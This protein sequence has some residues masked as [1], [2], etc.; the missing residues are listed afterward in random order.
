MT[1]KLIYGIQQIG[2]GVANADE[3][4]KWYATKLGADALIFDDS[5]EATYMA[6]Y[7]GGKS[8]KKRALLALNMQ[9]GGGFEIWQ[10]SNRTPAAPKNTF[11]IGDLG[12]QFPFIKTKDIYKTF[13]RL[14]ESK[15]NIISAICEEPDNSKSFYLKDPFNNILKIKEYSSWYQHNKLDVGGIF[16]AAIGVSNIETSLKL[17]SDILGYDTVVYDKSGVFKD[18][19]SLENGNTKVRR[20]LLSHS[21]ERTGGFS[22]LFGA[23]QIELIQCLEN[24]PDKIFVDRFWGDLGYIH[25]CFDI[26]NMDVLK[27]ECANKGVPF[28]VISTPSFDM[29]EAN[30]H[31]GYIEDFDGTLIEF[32][33]THKVPLIK[34]LGININLKNRDVKKPLP[35]WM[36]K[37]MNLKKVKKFKSKI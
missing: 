37:A 36:I 5:N 24:T 34:S 1:E 19:T 9:G 27:E 30:G 20:V 28:Q 16:G 8:R 3:A 4:F 15:E 26:K 31:W 35:H 10:F 18:L 23:S 7:M 33:E 13:H 2:I 17:Y 12:I 29:G 22:K 6:K 32:I 25:L 14:K 21:E 11:K